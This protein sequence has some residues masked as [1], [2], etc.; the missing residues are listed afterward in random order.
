MLAWTTMP[1]AIVHSHVA[2][3][4]PV[5]RHDSHATHHHHHD[6]HGHSH[7]DGHTH[8]EPTVAH[9]VTSGAYAK[10]CHWPW[11]GLW[12]TLP[13]P[14]QPDDR[15][16][17]HEAAKV[18]IVDLMDGDALVGVSV[19]TCVHPEGLASI[20]AI[21]PTVTAPLRPQRSSSS[22]PLCDSAR[23]ERSGVLLV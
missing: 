15:E 13:L 7:G 17:D 18:A 23:L 21:A 1:P 12:L 11:L 20:A 14:E 22:T 8:G 3:D 9:S 19:M 5:H 16:D 2:G 6:G 10:H 4:D